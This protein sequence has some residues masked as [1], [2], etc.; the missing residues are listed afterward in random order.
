VFSTEKNREGIQVGTAITTL[1]RR[2]EHERSE[3][4]NF[5]HFWGQGKLASLD[6]ARA[7]DGYISVLASLPMGL[8]FAPTTVDS[9]YHE[10]PSLPG[11]L[12]VSFPGVQTC[13]DDALVAID[14]ERLV[15]RMEQYFDHDAT[16]EEVSKSSPGLLRNSGT[17]V[18]R[19]VRRAL[20]ARGFRPDSV[21]RCAYR[22]FDDRW[23]YWELEGGLL[24][25]S[26][27][28]YHPHV[29]RDNLWLAAAQRNRREFDSPLTMHIPADRHVIERGANLFPAYLNPLASNATLLHHHSGPLVANQSPTALTYLDT[30][31]GEQID[32]FTHI[33]AV[34]HAPTYRSENAGALRQDWPRIPLPAS[35]DALVASADLGRVVAALLDIESPVDRVTAAAI[36]YELRP[37]GLPWKADGGQIAPGAGDLAVTA[38]WG[39]AGQGGVTMPGRGRLVER[40]YTPDELALMRE[41]L[42]DLDLTFEQLMSCLG[43]SCV[44][45]YLNERTYWRCVPSRVWTHTIGGYQVVKKWLSYRERALLGRDLSPDEARY[46]MEMARRIAAILLLEPALDANYEAVKA[47][48]YVW[49]PTPASTGGQR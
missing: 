10:W 7:R 6:R 18:G 42:V 11:L 33:L 40:A 36:R 22:P 27:P 32:L 3:I 17:F 9:A 21:V 5:R 29:A 19:N 12:P 41:G 28:E 8:T 31:D 37:V 13:R 16:D 4:V 26:R 45:V 44:D 46:V 1:A 35:A 24:D 47:D 43:G 49:Q 38:G 14:R 23:L 25:R 30:V 15:K 39:H 20:V 2:R 48:T 34:L